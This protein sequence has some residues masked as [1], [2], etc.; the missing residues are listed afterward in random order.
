MKKAPYLLL[1]WY[2]GRMIIKG[3]VQWRAAYWVVMGWILPPVGLEPG[4]L[5]SGQELLSK[6]NEAWHFMCIYYLALLLWKNVEMQMTSS[7]VV[8]GTLTF[9]ATITFAV[10]NF[11]KLKF[12]FV[13][14]FCFL[15]F[16]FFSK[17]ISLDISCESSAKQTIHI[18]CWD[19]FSLKNRM[20]SAM[21]GSWTPNTLGIN[22]NRQHIEIFI[23][24]FPRKQAL[25]VHANCLH[26]RQFAWNVKSFLWGKIRKS[27]A[28][29]RL[30]NLPMVSIKD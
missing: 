24:F 13:V 7:A 23:F 22:L 30:L 25:T 4:T 12:I 6:N 1:C 16:V 20:L 21:Y 2:D 18:K 14:F 10:G 28:V 15:L 17:K 5:W 8:I 26:W 29:C 3:S 11:L 19:L 9:K 27:S